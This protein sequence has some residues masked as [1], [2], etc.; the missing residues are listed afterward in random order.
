MLGKWNWG[1]RSRMSDA[2]IHVARRAAKGLGMWL[3]D[4]TIKSTSRRSIKAPHC[5]ALNIKPTS[6]LNSAVDPRKRSN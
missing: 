3:E 2:T 4:M 6:K 5:G 1:M